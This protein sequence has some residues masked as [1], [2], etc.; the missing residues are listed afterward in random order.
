[1]IKKISALT[2][3]T[4]VLVAPAIAKVSFSLDVEALSNAGG[5]ALSTT[6]LLVLVVDTGGDGFAGPTAGNLASGND[7]V[8]QSWDL[9]EAGPG[10]TA[11]TLLTEGGVTWDAEWSEGDPLALYWFPNLSSSSM[12]PAA[13]EAYGVFTDSAGIG[14]GDDWQMPAD[15]TFLHSLKLFTETATKLVIAG[16]FPASWGTAA[17]A[18]M[19]PPGSAVAPTS[20]VGTASGP[21][22]D[23]S[24]TDGDSAG[25]GYI[26]QRTPKGHGNWQ[27]IGFAP[28]GANA[29]SD[30]MISA[31]IEYEYR[32]IAGNGLNSATNTLASAIQ[33][34][35]LVL[36]SVSARAYVQEGFGNA[37]RMFGQVD[38]LGNANTKNVIFQASGPWMSK[39]EIG[40]SN[41]LTDPKMKVWKHPNPDFADR[42]VVAENDDWMVRGIPEEALTIESVQAEFGATT[43]RVNVFDENSKDASWYGNIDRGISYTFMLSSD[44]GAEGPGHIG[45]YNIEGGVD[46]ASSDN[47]ISALVTRGFLGGGTDRSNKMFGEFS[48]EGSAGVEKTVLIRGLGPNLVHYELGGVDASGNPI[49]DVK[50]VADPSIKLWRHLDPIND[51]PNRE[52]IAFNDNWQVQDW[53]GEASGVS[54][55]SDL[56]AINT[57]VDYVISKD[58]RQ[59]PFDAG[60]KDALLLVKL[61][62]GVYTFLLDTKEFSESGIGLLGIYEIEVADM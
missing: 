61:V 42:V 1:M 5:T 36:A 10:E 23:F 24:W 53:T 16:D 30:D 49:E 55:I 60:S 38:L 39:P 45:I 21:K 28:D 8:V 12:S 14:S 54:V 11:I 27:T 50:I 20:V 58:P 52:L 56:D 17:F 31:G 3:A 9:A 25:G 51:F 15:G 29:F 46:F 2:L 59:I 34:E 18:V 57:A 13:D 40:V 22:I 47:R 7:K 62:P 44:D 4:S 37:R 26:V 33:A 48:I 19:N 35:R 41:A 32:L 6:G 43:R